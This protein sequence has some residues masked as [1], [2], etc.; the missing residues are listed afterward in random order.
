MK[1]AKISLLEVIIGIWLLAILVIFAGVFFVSNPLSYVLGEVVGSATA[2]LM[3][4]HLYRSLDI[5]L[6]LPE[7]KAVNHAKF[8]SVVRSLIEIAVLAG[9]FFIAEWV[10]PYTVL[11][12]LL[13]RKFAAMLVPLMERIRTRGKNTVT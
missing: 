11:A 6:D 9:S 4:L 1:T 13:A 10:M 8:T 3:M 7:K 12:G 2:S 5:E